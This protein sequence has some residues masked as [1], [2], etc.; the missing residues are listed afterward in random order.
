MQTQKKEE[1]KRQRSCAESTSIFCCWLVGFNLWAKVGSHSLGFSSRLLFVML[2]WAEAVW[3]IDSPVPTLQA[4]LS[5]TFL[6]TLPDLV[7]P[8]KG[9]SISA[10]LSS[11]TGQHPPKGLGTNMTVEAT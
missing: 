8:L 4:L 5:G 6:Q 1:K 10:Q 2:S 9:H 7:M 3:V 11:N